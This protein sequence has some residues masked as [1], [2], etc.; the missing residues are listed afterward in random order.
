MSSAITHVVAAL[1][2]AFVSI[3]ASPAQDHGATP[4][5]H[6]V[7]SASLCADAY[8]LALFG[9]GEIQA[10][11]WQVDQPVSAAPD[12][13]RGYPQAWADAERLY[14]L[15]PALVVFGPGEGA[16]LAPLLAAAGIDVVQLQWGEDFATVRANISLLGEAADLV[17][18]ADEQIA[19]L[20][21]RL[22]EL[23]ARSVQRRDE[24]R[25]FY[26]SS[27][28][29][30]AGVGTYVDAAITAAGGI[31]LMTERGGR[32]WTRSDPELVLGLA[33][34]L[35]VTSFFADGYHGR[36]NRARYHAAYDDL[37]EAGTRIEIPSGDWPCAGPRLIHAAE[38]IADALDEMTVLQ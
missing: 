6:G 12:W 30:S 4:S 23:E 5:A 27:S 20:D 1:S 16:G 26:L 10:L 37:L 3:T 14:H 13:A 2:L 7:V 18:Q 28:G 38:A 17:A 29:G 33:A 21:T 19:T 31:N 11:S 35:V 25:V 15:D 8:V 9:P 34:D 22:A 36:L 32:S 24:T